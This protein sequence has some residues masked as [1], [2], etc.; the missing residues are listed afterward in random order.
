MSTKIGRRTITAGLGATAAATLLPH[1]ARADLAA[2]EQAARREGA[3]TWYIAQVDGET[4]E[5]MGRAFTARYP[6]I[7]VTVIRT[8]GQVAYERLMQDLKNNAPQCDVFSS[9]DIAHYPALIKRNAL[10]H[11]EPENAAALAPAFQGM[12]ETGLYYPTTASLQLLVYNTRKV[13]PEDAPKAWTDLLDA[14]W[15]NQACSGH[16][17]FSGYVG[18][19]ALALNRL[20]GWQYFEKLAA[21]RP[22]IGRSGLDPYT[23]LNAGERTVGAAPL[24]GALLNQDK[25]NPIGYQ[26]PTDGAVLL[27]GPAAVMANA[28]HPNAGRLF[29]EWLLGQEFARICVSTGTDPVRADVTLRPGVKPNSELKLLRLTTQEIA[30]GVPDMIE[31]W[32]DTFG[33]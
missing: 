4:A 5:L 22:L 10:A 28:P 27:I 2:L 18:I 1:R 30:T 33:A 6:G 26:Y 12:G 19:W 21:N 3:L 11:F 31:R 13:K 24:F 29:M 8:T 25:G 32:R 17:A 7:T 9:T 16:P 14:K 20:Y 15:K 23:N